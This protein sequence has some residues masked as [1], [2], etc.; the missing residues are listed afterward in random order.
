M[1]EA[2]IKISMDD[3]GTGYSSLYL[4]KDRTFDVVK[5]DKSFVD[6]ITKDLPKDKVI[7]T[8]MIRMLKE[9][10]VEITAEGV[11]SEDQIKFLKE[12]GCQVIQGYFYDKPLPHDEFEK[13]LV[14]RKYN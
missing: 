12:S 6:N 1:R 14:D 8:N 4:F 7:L 10:D 3:F 11:E 2:G 5:I 13:R 9:L